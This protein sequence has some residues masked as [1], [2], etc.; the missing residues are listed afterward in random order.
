MDRRKDRLRIFNL[1]FNVTLHFVPCHGGV[2]E[3]SACKLTAQFE[4]RDPEIY[5]IAY[6][7]CY[8]GH[9]AD[10]LKR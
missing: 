7:P 3:A 8:T 1:N 5:F 4:T 9:I 10:T 6:C 2:C